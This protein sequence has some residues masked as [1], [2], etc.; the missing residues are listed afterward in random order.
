[1]SRYAY[2]YLP[3]YTHR[4]T[5]TWEEHGSLFWAFYFFKGYPCHKIK[6]NGDK[7]TT[8]CDTMNERV[9]SYFKVLSR[10]ETLCSPPLSW[11]SF[12]W[13]VGMSYIQGGLHFMWQLMRRLNTHKSNFSGQRVDMASTAENNPSYYPFALKAACQ[14]CLEPLWKETALGTSAR[15]K[16]TCSLSSRDKNSPWPINPHTWKGLNL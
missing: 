15:M 14:R 11:Q 6:I 2:T 4:A 7:H 12:S 10:W 16:S 9:N 1:M 3:M 13:Q 8:T 5:G